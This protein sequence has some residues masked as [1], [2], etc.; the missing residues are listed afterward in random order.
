M[1][2]KTIHYFCSP[3]NSLFNRQL[4]WELL[5]YEV[6]K[7]T[8]NYKK[9]IA[10]E[11]RQQKTNLENQKYAAEI[12]NFLSQINISKLSE[13]KANLCLEDLTKKD[14]YNSLKT[15]QN[16]KSPGNDR[17]TKEF[18]EIFWN[19]LKEIF[20]DSVSETKEKRHLSASQRQAII[21]LSEKK[22]K[23]RDS[24]KIVDQFLCLM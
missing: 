1:Y 22:I 13:E 14:L 20:V 5:K 19:E 24:Y 10:K 18:Y 16:D 2:I 8:I 6:R 3:N 9:H 21:R 17:L 11:K 7:F 12:R 23:I 4:K 15:M